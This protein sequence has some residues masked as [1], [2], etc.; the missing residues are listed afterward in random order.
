MSAMSVVLIAVV[1]ASDR[2]DLLDR[3]ISP[4]LLWERGEVPNHGDKP[5][6]AFGRRAAM[7]TRLCLPGISIIRQDTAWYLCTAATYKSDICSVIV[8]E[9][10]IRTTVYGLSS[11]FDINR[12]CVFATKNHRHN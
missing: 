2:K 1:V 5:K 9:L 12:F 7:D 6:L 11:L 10:P 4:P 3:V 8:L